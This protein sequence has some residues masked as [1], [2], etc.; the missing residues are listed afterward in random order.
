[1]VTRVL[2]RAIVAGLAAALAT[3]VV[4]CGHTREPNSYTWRGEV[5]P[6]AWVRISNV[7]GPIRVAR[8]EGQ[9]VVVTA[10]KRFRGRHPQTVRMLTQRE[11]RDVRVC[12]VWGSR[13]SGCTQRGISGV[14]LLGRLFRQ[15]SPTAMDFVVAVP[16]GVRVQAATV[17]GDVV[18]ADALGEVRA[19]ATNGSVTVGA[20]G[21]PIRARTVNGPITARLA[22]LAPGAAVTLASTNGAITAMLPAALDAS[23]DLARTN[24]RIATDFLL[25]P[26]TPRAR[27]LHGVLG[28]GGRPVELKTVNGD[29]RL[30]Q[31]R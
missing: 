24:G 14:G 29:V 3:Q 18:V 20:S 23:I 8:A 21:G 1:M 12:A 17:N 22:A 4:G 28:A 9:E 10:T 5:A 25:A 27:R 15:T 2:R 7:N 26:S 30:E 19:S 13:H 31:V 6:G 16:G 11:G